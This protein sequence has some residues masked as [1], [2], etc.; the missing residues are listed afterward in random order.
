M[1]NLLDS[2]ISSLSSDEQALTNALRKDARKAGW[3]TSVVSSL[4]VKAGPSGIYVE[5]PEALAETVEDLEYGNAATPPSAVFRMFGRAPKDDILSTL[6]DSS[7]DYL[8]G[9]DV[10][11]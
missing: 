11:P 5:Y 9:K 10:I 8:I 4:L 6:S 2:A 3:P 7:V 1:S